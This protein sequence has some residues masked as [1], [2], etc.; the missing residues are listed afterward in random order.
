[1]IR[2]LV[3]AAAVPVVLAAGI[4]VASSTG[5]PAEDRTVV[6]TMDEYTLVA[7]DTAVPAGTVTFETRNEGAVEHELLVVRTDLEPEKLPLGL[8]GPAVDLAGEVVL[9]KAH[10]HHAPDGTGPGRHVAAGRSR[11]ESVVLEPGRYVLL[12]SLPGHYQA[13]QRAALVVTR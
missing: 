10:S 13:G 3:L 9:G 11:A 7:D 5:R 12:C 6:A 2:R 8:E 1:M 4:A